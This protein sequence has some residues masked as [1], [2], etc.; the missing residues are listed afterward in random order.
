MTSHIKVSAITG[1]LNEP[2]ARFRVRQYISPLVKYNVLVTEHLPFIAKSS[3]Y[4]YHNYPLALQL[5]PQ[6]GTAGLRMASRIPAIISSYKSDITLIQREFL[7][8]FSTT[9]G[10]T[11]RP[12]IF[13]LDDAIWLRLNFTKG[14]AK[15]IVRKMDGLICGNRWL[16]DYFSDCG[17]PT[18]IVPTGVDTV[19]WHP[20]PSN[21]EKPFYLGWM[22][23]SGNFPY[24][25]KLD[26][27]LH[28]FCTKFPSTKVLIISDREPHFSFLQ[29]KYVQYIRWSK[30]IEVQ[31]IQQMDIGL[32][33]LTNSDWE[34]GKCSFKMLLY[35][36]TGIPVVVSPVGMNNEILNIGNIGFGPSNQSEWIEALTALYQDAELRKCFGLSGRRVVEQRFSLDALTPQ[37]SNIFRDFA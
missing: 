35:M 33:P 21:P 9:E 34:K 16:A 19:R 4:W 6:V 20:A 30:E 5:I 28:S 14:F 1:G 25:Y 13:D 22:G 23:T 31:A 2:S 8:A 10:L 36:A 24:L 12:R 15:K 29:P 3:A 32:M 17:V 11:K 37:L 7:T 18:W 27:V 26:K